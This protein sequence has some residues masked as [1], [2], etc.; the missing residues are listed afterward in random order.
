MS[1]YH[2]NLSARKKDDILSIKAHRSWSGDASH[3]VETA[4]GNEA[5]GGTEHLISGREVSFGTSTSYHSTEASSGISKLKR[6]SQSG[7]G[8][9]YSSDNHVSGGT[10][11]SGDSAGGG[12]YFDLEGGASG[13]G[14]DV[15]HNHNR[16]SSP[17][18]DQ[19][20]VGQTSSMISAA[21]G[22]LGISGQPRGSKK[23]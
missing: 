20:I 3:T 22:G 15:T 4:I 9:M 10:G 17:R 6:G 18:H 11:G 13:V 21:L 12:V 5:A 1:K 16:S 8:S 14:G 2:N 23:E 19:P 7:S